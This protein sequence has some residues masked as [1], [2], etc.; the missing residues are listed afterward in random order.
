MAAT[1]TKAALDKVFIGISK[2]Q[3]SPV[4]ALATTTFDNADEIYTVKDSV[5][6]S[7]AQPS[8][9]EIKVDQMSSAIACTYDSGEFT[10]TG[11][12]PSIAKEILSYFF[13]T[14]AAAITPIT[15]FTKSTA[16]DL[17]NKVI[18]VMV[19]ITNA[20]G[21]MAIVIPRCEFIAN[22]DW[23]STSSSAFAVSFT[24]TPKANPDNKGDVLFY[25][26]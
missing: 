10:I 2:I 16:V 22:F 1:L 15:G 14:N 9:T 11:K 7:Q 12:I 24:A 8:K 25:E 4:G 13:K 21:D 6:F 26:K 19:K 20:A 18:N 17:E 23:T 5:S 3:L